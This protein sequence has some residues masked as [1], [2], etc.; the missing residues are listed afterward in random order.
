MNAL[1][2]LLLIKKV[3]NSVL[4]GLRSEWRSWL[5]KGKSRRNGN[6][7]YGN[8]IYFLIKIY[9]WFVVVCK[10]MNYKGWP[11]SRG[12]GYLTE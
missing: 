1:D 3:W 8:L 11:G 5:I 6:L 12:G 7:N 9:L 10:R 2:R 4:G